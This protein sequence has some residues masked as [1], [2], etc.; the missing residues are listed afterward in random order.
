MPREATDK[1]KSCPRPSQKQYR[2][3]NLPKSKSIATTLRKSKSR[4]V[5]SNRKRDLCWPGSSWPRIA[6]IPWI[7]GFFSLPLCIPCQ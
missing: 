1:A 7:S 3:H 6:E 2:V 5:S 4:K